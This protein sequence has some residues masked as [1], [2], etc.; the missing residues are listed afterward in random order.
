MKNIASVIL[1]FLTLYFISRQG[2]D[3]VKKTYFKNYK[4]TDAKLVVYRIETRLKII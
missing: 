3:R 1:Q 4:L 2:R